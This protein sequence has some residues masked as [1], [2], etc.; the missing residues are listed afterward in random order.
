MI[1]TLAEQRARRRASRSTIV[2]G[3][4]D[5]FQLIDPESRV[6][7]MATARGITETKLYD[8]QAVIDRYGIAPE[9][10]PDFYGLKGDTSDNIPGVPGIGDKTAADLLQRFGDLETVLGSIDEISGAK[11]KENLVNHADDARIS[12]Q[13]ATIQRD[14]PGVDDARLGGA[15]PRARPLEA[16]RG[17]PRVRAARPA[18]PPRGVLGSRGR[19]GAA[20]RRPSR[21][22]RPR[23]CARSTVDELAEAAGRQPTSRWPCCRPRPPRASCSRARRTPRF[24]VA[25]GQ[26]GARR[27]RRDAG[28]GRARAR[29]PAGHRPRRQVARRRAA[30]PRPR[31]AARRVPARAGAPRLPVPRAV[32]GARAR[33]RRRGRRPPTAPCSCASSRRWQ[34]EQHR[35]AR[36][37]AGSW[38]R[39]S[40]R[41]SHV[42][43]AMEVEGV[44]L[45]VERLDEIGARVRDE[46]GRARARDLGRWPARSSR[47]ARRSSSARSCSTSS[48]C[49]RSAAA[50]PASRP[51][52]AC[53]RR[54]ATSTRS[55]RRSSAGASSTSSSRPTSTCCRSWSTSA[56][57]STRRS[58]RP[59]RR[60]GG[61]PRPTRTCRTSRSARRS[62]ARSA[63]ASRP[64]RA[65]VLVSADYSQVELRILA[66]VADEPVLKEIF[67]RGE[68][69][70]TATASQ[71]FGKDAGRPDADGSLEGQDDQLRDRLRP[72][73]LR[74]RRP[75]EHPA[76][77]GQGVHRRLPRALPAVARVHDGDDR[78]G[79][80]AGLRHDAVRPPPPDPRAPGAQLPGAHARRAA[81]GQHR[82]P[83]H[84]GRRDEA[85]DD[86]RAPT[87]STPR[88]SRRG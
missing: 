86:P 68:D 54:S 40:C 6:K 45:N 72:Q 66:H 69:V 11:R 84:R 64:P 83:G 38:T 4:R 9:Q 46:V 70:H 34:R 29:R 1:A 63:A 2:T 67:L 48:A 62:A 52:R 51:T 58:C 16:A 18:A 79:D 28:G 31:H 15:R 50:R 75:A 20:R 65:S 43:R 25:G 57:G 8:H 78:A 27:R 55:S 5:A 56:A 39:S 17:L 47:S 30:E 36:P 87:R 26:R 21:P 85:G 71:V 53:S 77:G 59:A 41:S 12:K 35:G 81:R 10:I 37:R 24:G 73:R 13:L 88:A 80:G 19:G 33:R 44:R 76:R 74:P 23:A 42:L 61:S 60:P 49:R 7:V 32:R 3:D 22:S 82:D 14:V